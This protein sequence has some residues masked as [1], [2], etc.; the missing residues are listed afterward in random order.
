MS[1]HREF[2]QEI[3][4]GKSRACKLTFWS[5]PGCPHGWYLQDWDEYGI[6]FNAS[7]DPWRLPSNEGWE[8]YTEAISRPGTLP[9][10][11]V[12]ANANGVRSAEFE[13]KEQIKNQVMEDEEHRNAR[14]FTS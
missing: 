4:E 11:L 9:V 10:P 12:R 3:K 5:L 1:H 7:N 8:P 13:K 6:Y 2:V 14:H